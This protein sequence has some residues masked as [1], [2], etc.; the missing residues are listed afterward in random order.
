MNT[1]NKN[2]APVLIFWNLNF[3][4]IDIMEIFLDFEN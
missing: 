3:G 1:K 4:V 2:C